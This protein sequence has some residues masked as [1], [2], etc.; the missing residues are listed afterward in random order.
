MAMDGKELVEKLAKLSQVQSIKDIPQLTHA[1]FP[2]T[3]C[4]LMGAAMAVG[5]IKDSLIV[6]VGT[7]ECTYYTK[8]MTIHS[9]KFGALAAVVFQSFW[10]TMM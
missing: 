6:V 2:G 1:L 3:H 8:S 4:P 5:G 10:M 7:D 9:E